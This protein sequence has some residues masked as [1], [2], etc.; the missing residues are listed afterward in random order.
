MNKYDLVKKVFER[1]INRKAISIRKC[2][3]LTFNINDVYVIEAEDKLYILKVFHATEYPER[4]KMVY[5]SKKL[6]EHSIP[7]AK[8]Y[9]YNRN[10]NDF[11]GGYI[12]EEYLPGKTVDRLKL[13]EN[14]TCSMYKKLAV[15]M[16]EIHQI[17]FTRFGFI[18]GG[19]PDCKTFTEHIHNEF[20]YGNHYIHS[21]FTNAELSKIKSI[22]IERLKPCDEMQ[23]CLCHFDVQP[24]NILAHGD[25]ITLIDWDDARSFPAVVDIARLTLLIELAYDNEKAEESE[26]TIIYRKAFLDYYSTDYGL[27]SYYDYEILLHV[28]HGLVLLNYCRDDIPQFDKIKAVV[29]KKIQHITKEHYLT[30][31]YTSHNKRF[32]EMAVGVET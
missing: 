30:S 32:S 14:E 24:K 25:C 17:K 1:D 7:H 8:I 4:G 11:Q 9:S 26:K 21:A 18:V 12:I 2:D 6:A 28:W 3:N 15:M 13:T 19:M 27:R 29:D 5:I 31:G 22:L 16:S 23:P 10:D 20:I